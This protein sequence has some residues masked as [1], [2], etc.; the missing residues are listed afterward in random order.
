MTRTGIIQKLLLGMLAVCSIIAAAA[1]WVRSRPADTTDLPIFAEVIRGPYE[2]IVLEQGEIQSSNNV[3]VRCQVKNRAGGDSPSTT[4]LDVIPEGTNV[5]PGDWLATFDSTA[6]ENELKQQT[7]TVKT[8]ETLVIQARAA[9]DTAL[10]AKTEYLKGTY[11]QERKTNQNLIF[12]A[13]ENLKKAELSYDSIKRS[14]SRGLISSLQLQG[15]EFRV[16]AARKDLELAKQNLH[17]LENFTKEKMVTQLTSDIEA[18]KIQWENMEASYS[19][20]M[21]KLEEIKSQIES[22]RLVAPQAGQ[23]VYANVQSRRSGSEFVV[24]AG[25]AV[26]E[27]Q[28]II[29]LPDPKKMQVE[30]KI[31]ETQINLVREGM[32]ASIRVDAFNTDPLKGVVTKVNKYSEPG[33]WWSSTGK[34]YKTFVEILKPPPQ[35]RSGLTAEVR[36]HVETRP[37]ALQMPVQAVLEHRGETF[38][39]VR[40]PDGYSTRRISF[41]SMNNKTVAIDD[42]SVEV[43]DKV[44]LN[45]RQYLHLFDFSGFP[46]LQ[47]QPPAEVQTAR[48]SADEN[49]THVDHTPQTNDSAS[50]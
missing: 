11:E 18:T 13:E 30:A 24:E 37:N 4:I 17:V 21:A 43:G 1:A 50:S 14:V 2:H 34:E 10:I 9:Y 5:E 40:T 44:V 6:L 23:V 16:D 15:E 25:A 48:R 33:N 38:C 29:R 27:R 46:D 19:E 7:I 8:A 36:I 42:A 47:E 31:S 49:T 28:V 26:R 20:E 32:E 3:E 22:C 12:V 35:L 45:P 39:L 41:D